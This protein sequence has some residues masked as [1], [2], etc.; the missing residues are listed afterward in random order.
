MSHK[1]ISL[2]NVIRHNKHYRVEN[3]SR[4]KEALEEDNPD[5]LSQ[6]LTTY[7]KKISKNEKMTVFGCFLLSK[8]IHTLEPTDKEKILSSP[9]LADYLLMIQQYC[10]ANPLGEF[11]ESETSIGFFSSVINELKS[12]WIYFRRRKFFS[13]FLCRTP[14]WGPL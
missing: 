1:F 7:I 13:G 6:S 8:F 10:A 5:L 9:L 11:C 2:W 14:D 3:I 4:I 12:I